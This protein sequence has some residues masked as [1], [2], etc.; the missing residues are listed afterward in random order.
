M[1]FKTFAIAGISGAVSK[2][3]LQGFL[4]LPTVPKIF[5]LSRQDKPD[6]PSHPNIT[7]LK[8]D[9]TSSDTIAASLRGKEIEDLNTIAGNLLA[10][11][12]LVQAVKQVGIKLFVPSEF[13]VIPKE[14]SP[15]AAKLTIRKLAEEQGIPTAIYLNGLFAE[16][17]SWLFGKEKVRVLNENRIVSIT[18]FVDV[19]RFLAW[20]LT[21]LPDEQL[22][23]S[24]WR[25]EGDRLS[26]KEVAEML[27]N[28]YD[29]EVVHV[30]KDDLPLT[31]DLAGF[32]NFFLLYVGFPLFVIFRE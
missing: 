15:L 31:Q 26:V 4:D 18:S 1:P 2:A 8:V 27:K 30:T 5:I 28:K 7:V 16:Y 24:I 10:Q 22:Y 25:L 32:I 23:N 17:V 14:N 21:T 13:G 11:E 12:P 20:S 9:Y 19:G 6:I 29:A 3:F